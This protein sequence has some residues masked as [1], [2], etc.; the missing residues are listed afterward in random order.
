[1]DRQLFHG[2]VEPMT[3]HR[4]RSP[5]GR[6]IG[7]GSARSG[8]EHWW[9]QRVSAM[10]LV[11]LTLW[12]VAN[13]INHT[14]SDYIDFVTWLRTPAAMIITILVLVFLFHHTALGLQVVIEDYVHSD[15][16]F[17]AVIVMRLCCFA[18]A[19]AGIVAVFEIAFG[20]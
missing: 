5:L 6:A 9:A 17:A 1:M 3:V 18:L 7:L 19:V 8:V 2:G 12:F 13:I 11:P 10:A 15:A 16:R 14:G 4:T 20:I